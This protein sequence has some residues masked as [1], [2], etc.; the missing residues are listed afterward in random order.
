LATTYWYA[1]LPSWKQKQDVTA[2]FL[3][4]LL[5]AVGLAVIPVSVLKTL[6]GVRILF[7]R[8]GT[9]VA[10]LDE[11]L[12]DYYRAQYMWSKS[13]KYHHDHF[14]YKRLPERL[15]PEFLKPDEDH[16]T[17]LADVKTSFGAAG[18]AQAD[19]TVDDDAKHKGFRTR[20]GQ[21][22]QGRRRRRG[23]G[24]G[25]GGKGRNSGKGH[26]S[27]DQVKPYSAVGSDSD[28]AGAVAT[29]SDVDGAPPLP[30]PPTTQ[31]SWEFNHGEGKWS[32]F[33]AQHQEEVER[34]FQEWKHR[35]GAPRLKIEV[36]KGGST[37]RVSLDFGRLT[38]MV[39]GKVRP[40]RRLEQ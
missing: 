38:Q 6:L 15:N 18:A 7:W 26:D 37:I 32:K 22:P 30:P 3:P 19:E 17:K 12:N 29:D 20:K 40:I 23:K 35:G 16:T 24:G 14:L 8:K 28:T 27:G 34:G 13:M 2:F 1:L 36:E 11:S 5:V 31:V 39:H 33:A 9:K 21:V 25:K 10:N 4:A